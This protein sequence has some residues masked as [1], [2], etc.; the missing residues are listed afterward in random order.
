MPN[1]TLPNMTNGSQGIEAILAY[2]ASQVSWIAGGLLFLVY[3]VILG[4]GYFA[5]ERRTGAGNIFMWAS[6]SGLITTTGAFILF[7]YDLAS[8]TSLI[9]IEIVMICVIVTIVCSFAFILSNRD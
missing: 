9:N 3:C 2:D 5:Q 7:L 4:V 6:I 8:G 1:Y